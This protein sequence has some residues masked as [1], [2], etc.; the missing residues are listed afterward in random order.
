MGYN[1]RLDSIQAAVLRV[2]LKH[3]DRWNTRRGAIARAYKSKVRGEEYSFQEAVPGSESVY[4][5][6]AIRHPRRR[7]V[8]DLLNNAGIGWGRHIVPPI[9]KQPGYRH[10]VR[11]GEF[12]PVSET[13]S[14][15][16]VSLPVFPELT[17]EQVEYVAEVLGKIEVSV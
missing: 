11:N 4:H 1:C 8:Q 5:I 14:E 9:H 10:L 17:D 15:Q 6:M 12:F 7:L 3:L 16:L 2:K 13:L